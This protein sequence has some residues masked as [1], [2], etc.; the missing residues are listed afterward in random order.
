VSVAEVEAKAAGGL[1]I[2]GNLERLGA[3]TPTSLDLPP[4]TTYEQY[5]AVG[6]A[7][8]RAHRNISWKIADWLNFGEHVHG[9]K[10]EQAALVLNMNPDTL[11][12]YAS[13]GRRVPRE[14]RR[15]ELP[16]SVHGLVAALEP[17][18][19]T[20]WLERAS[21]ND[22]AREE[23]RDH[24]RGNVDPVLPVVVEPAEVVEDAARHLVRSAVRMGDGFLVR[25]QAFTTL[26]AALGELA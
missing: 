25:E 10:Y 4:E 18:A 11:R 22:W 23:L 1:E 5:E 12:N 15:P 20:E 8:G 14:R 6:F 13:I 21:T 2:L 16:F 17:A 3:A 24:M 26:A 7:L 9:T 19:Q